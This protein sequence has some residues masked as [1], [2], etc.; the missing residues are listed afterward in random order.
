MSG[1]EEILFEVTNIQIMEQTLK[2]LGHKYVKTGNVLSIA[3]AYHPIEISNRMIS[4]D[5]MNSHEV[6]IIKVE[7]QRDYQIYE[8]AVRGEIYEMTETSN[9]IVITV[10]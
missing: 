7:Y 9:E 6:G 8:R 3:R 2:K 10:H 5:T 4:C 1:R